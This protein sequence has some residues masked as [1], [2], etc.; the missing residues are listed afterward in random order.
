MFQTIHKLL[1]QKNFYFV[2]KM[3]ILEYSF[4][5]FDVYLEILQNWNHKLEKMERI[6]FLTII[7]YK[8]V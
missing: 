2:T 1:S 5:Q 8:I 4:F 6:I 3:I 7:E